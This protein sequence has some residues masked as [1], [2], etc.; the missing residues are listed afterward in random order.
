VQEKSKNGYGYGY[1]YG[2]NSY[3]H[4]EEGVKKW[5][6]KILPNWKKKQK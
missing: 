2:Y 4:E 6:Q 5:W 1:G 3:Y